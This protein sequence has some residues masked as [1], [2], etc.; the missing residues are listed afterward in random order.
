[1]KCTKCSSTKVFLE[2]NGTVHCEDCD[3]NSMKP[4]FGLHF[5]PKSD[6]PYH[7]LVCIDQYSVG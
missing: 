4:G 5:Q 3:N 7:D 1:M 6:D 2:S